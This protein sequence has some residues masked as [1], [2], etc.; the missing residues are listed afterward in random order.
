[1]QKD[2]TNKTKLNLPFKGKWFVFW[3]GDTK[4]LNN[5]HGI[6]PQN[7]AYDFCI[8]DKAGKSYTGDTSDLNSYHC[9]GKDVLSPADGIVM[10]A[11]DG[12]MDNVPGS[13]NNYMYPGNYLLIKHTKNEYSLLGHLKQRS[14]LVKEGDQVKMGQKLAQVGNSGNSTEPHL[15]YHIQNT[16]VFIKYDHGE[17]VQIAKSVKVFFS[18]LR[19]NGK[20]KARHTLERGETVQTID[21]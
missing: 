19:V 4:E 8:L 2:K 13:A 9:F 12:L 17:K 3:G 5:H 16:P 18:D 14:L 10:E 20:E 6:E 7:Y 1:M 21:I 11:V 15:H